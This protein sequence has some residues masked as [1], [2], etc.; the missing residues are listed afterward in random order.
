MQ[1]WF[2]VCGLG[3]YQ[4]LEGTPGEETKCSSHIHFV[5]FT[6]RFTGRW[7]DEFTYVAIQSTYTPHSDKN[8]L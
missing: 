4:V 6:L 3:P 7:F 1:K 8:S 5:L 2:S